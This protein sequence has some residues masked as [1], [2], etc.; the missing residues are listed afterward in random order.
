MPFRSFLV[1]LAGAALTLTALPAAAQVAE[2][3]MRLA[4]PSGASWEGADPPII[5]EEGAAY[6]TIDIDISNMDSWGS[7]DDPDNARFD[8]YLPPNAHVIGAGWKTNQTAYFPSLIAGMIMSARGAG[9]DGIFIDPCIL[10]VFPGTLD[11]FSLGLID[12]E[13]LGFDFYAEPDGRVEIQLFELL[14]SIHDDADG[15][16]NELSTLTLAYVPGAAAP[17]EADLWCN[18]DVDAEGGIQAQVWP[19]FEAAA[20]D[21]FMIKDNCWWSIDEVTVVMAVS[22]GVEPVTRLNIGS[23]CDGR[24]DQVL[25]TF[26]QTGF[27]LIG[28][29]TGNLDGTDLWEITYEVYGD[30]DIN[31][32]RCPLMLRGDARYWLGPYGYSDL[33]V[34]YWVTAGDGK[35][36]GS[37]GQYQ[38]GAYG[39]HEWTDVDDVD[40]D[41]I[42]CDDF[43]FKIFGHR[44]CLLRDQGEYDLA[45][46]SSLSF[47]SSS[48]FSSRAVDQFQVPPARPGQDG[49]TRVCRIEAY[50]ATNCL[51]DNTVGEVWPNECDMPA[52]DPIRL[53]NPKIFDTGDTY[54]GMP[55]YCFVWSYPDLALQ[56]GENY[57][58]SIVAEGH[59]V[60]GERGIF[61]F[62][63]QDPECDIYIRQ[64]KYKNKFFGYDDFTNVE[65]VV[66][67]PG[68]PREFA[69]R[70]WTQKDDPVAAAPN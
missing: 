3:G 68:E 18:G 50:L 39:Y 20:A 10:C 56:P 34:Y 46:M 4:T 38:S 53:A 62:K 49:P 36:Q 7:K 57:W 61:L 14:D 45:G 70:V 65:D 6:E 29:G 21:D 16:Y 12:L 64:G 35:I 66:G 13:F 26:E 5:E 37:Q 59:G 42:D 23:D 22:R 11:L 43:A 28:P 41:K 52:G 33:G 55:V 24:P 47:P 1:A 17:I 30:I 27:S 48:L 58:F 9:G 51:V 54:A 8:V 60:A 15:R 40:S 2:P 25:Y 69:F 32:V 67:G 19:P 31:D 44:C 63:A